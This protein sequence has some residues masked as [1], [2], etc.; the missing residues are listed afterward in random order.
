MPITLNQS[1][2]GRVLEVQASGKLT[3]DDY[4]AF[5]A[6]FDRLLKQHGRVNV[7]FEMV[8]F[9]GWDAGGFWDD[10]KFDLKHFA[11]VD[12]FAMVGDQIWEKNITDLA[13]PFTAA[14]VRYFDR[15]DI[16]AARWWAAG[17]AVPV[18]EPHI[19]RR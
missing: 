8:D 18:E 3:H 7:L 5:T 10:V 2:D 16:E 15:T 11:D 12:R 9:H 14:Q 6:R 17:A 4:Q 1:S 13:R 19:T